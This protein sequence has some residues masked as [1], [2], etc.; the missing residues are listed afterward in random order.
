MFKE[1]AEAMKR[2]RNIW[3]RMKQRTG[4]K[5]DRWHHADYQERGITCCDEWRL[6]FN[7]FKKWALENGYSPDLTLDRIDNDKG[8]SPENCRWAD[9]HTQRVNQR[10]HVSQFTGERTDYVK[11]A[12]LVGMSPNTLR[13]RVR[14]G[15]S[16]SDAMLT[17]V[18]KEE[19]DGGVQPLEHEDVS[20]LPPEV[21]GAVDNEGNQVEGFDPEE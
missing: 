17:P 3:G 19:A 12:A 15:M 21:S 13:S 7:K 18:T 11:L 20:G 4:N 14:R 2:L 9:K 5:Y 16:L 6:S 8:Y 1:K 10:A